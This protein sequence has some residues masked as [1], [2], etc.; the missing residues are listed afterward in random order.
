MKYL[1]LLAFLYALTFSVSPTAQISAPMVD[2][3]VTEAEIDIALDL[4]Y[5]TLLNPRIGYVRRTP[6][7]ASPHID[8]I[9]PI[10][11]GYRVEG[12]YISIDRKNGD[13]SIEEFHL[14]FRNGK[15]DCI[16]IGYRVSE[17][18]ECYKVPANAISAQRE[19]ALS[20]S[21]VENTANV[22]VEPIIKRATE[23]YEGYVYCLNPKNSGQQ[24]C[25][26]PHVF[27]Y[28]KEAYSLYQR[29]LEDNEI[30]SAQRGRAQSG[31]NS[32]NMAL[33]K[34]REEHPMVEKQ[35]RKNQCY[36]SARANQKSCDNGVNRE[37]CERQR[38]SAEIHCDY[39]ILF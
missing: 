27:D 10:E 18:T 15:I 5:Q 39:S 16:K 1:H 23:F 19:R 26:I 6:K 21:K 22:R 2:S 3:P 14:Y 8:R 31:L 7:N 17:R 38:R 30:G 12:R 32:V 34:L 35:Q 20:L 4:I 28:L 24:D 9:A 36:A 29:V 11:S 25:T 33:S 13:D 37:F